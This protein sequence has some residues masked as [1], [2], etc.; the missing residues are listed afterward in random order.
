MVK[1]FK[2]QL[3]TLRGNVIAEI[4]RIVE[5]HEHPAN[6]AEN[7]EFIIAINNCDDDDMINTIDSISKCRGQICVSYHNAFH[8]DDCLLCR[9]DIATLIAILDE[10]EKNANLFDP[11]EDEEE[12]E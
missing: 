10:M 2:E 7:G 4:T 12:D 11:T 5:A 9:L 3:K 1:R 8:E 6:F